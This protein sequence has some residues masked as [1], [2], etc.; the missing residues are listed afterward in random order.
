MYRAVFRWAAIAAVTVWG[1]CFP[2][3]VRGARI[4]VLE[5]DGRAVV[6]NDRFLAPVQSTPAPAAFVRVQLDAVGSLAGLADRNVETELARLRRA[7]AISV[8]AYHA[9]LASF[10]AA[11]RSVGELRGTRAGELEAVIANLQSIAARG[12]LTPSRLPALFLT[13][14]RNR[15]WWTS[16][17]LLRAYQRVEFAGSGIVWE[18]YPGQGIELQVLGSFSSAQWQCASRRRR[19]VAR[20]AAL[21]AEL[22]PLAAHRAG[23]LTWEYYFDFGGG[24]PPWA[25]AIS[26]GTA[27]QAL[28]DAYKALR[29]PYYLTIGNLALSAFTVAPPSGVAVRTRLGARYVEY[30]F[31][32]G[33]GDE[34]LNAFLQ[35]LIGLDDYAH[36]S[37][38]PRAARLFAAGNAEAQHEVPQFDTGSWSLYQPGVA[39]DLAYHEF[40]TGLLQQ[41]CAMTKA[42]VYCTTAAHFERYLK[43]RRQRTARASR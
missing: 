17:P 32:P 6:Q 39:D 20:C 4:L 14:N 36:A 12:F 26:Q 25:S 35:S 24:L 16:G 28:A 37:K 41:L 2:A 7:N 43:A 13:L 5:H 33:R 18:Y 9:Y 15:Q 23:G 40:V 42:R 3:V 30:T 19:V 21:L 31:D 38:N 29:N 22:I 1:L 27:V 34:V 10:N 8:G 11:L